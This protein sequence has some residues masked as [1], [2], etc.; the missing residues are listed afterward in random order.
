MAQWARGTVE[1][2]PILVVDDVLRPEA[3]TLL[4][5]Y[6]LEAPLWCVVNF[7]H[8]FAQ[9]SRESVS[10]WPRPPIPHDTSVRERDRRDVE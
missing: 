3:L 10:V 2:P 1:E 5:E 8:A 4:Q 9:N 7:I 6:M